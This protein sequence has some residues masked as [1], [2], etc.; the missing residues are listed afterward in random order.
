MIA[1]NQDALIMKTKSRSD[2]MPVIK[3]EIRKLPKEKK[4]EIIQKLTETMSEITNIPKQSFTIY[5]NEYDFDS[6]GVG[7]VPLSELHK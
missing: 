7:G 5:I 1:D 3:L 2:I 6:I 4:S